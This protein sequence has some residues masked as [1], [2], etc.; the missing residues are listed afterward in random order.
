MGPNQHRPYPYQNINRPQARVQGRPNGNSR[1]S[2]ENR[3]RLERMR[4]SAG[5]VRNSCSYTCG[6]KR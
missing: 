3:Q 6:G 5:A 2:E 4:Q 1:M